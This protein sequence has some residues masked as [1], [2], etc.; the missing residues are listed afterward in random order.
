MQRT[1]K[2]PEADP[3]WRLK[4][5]CYS[6]G[7]ETDLFFPVGTTGPAVEQIANAK[8]VCQSCIAKLAC[9]EYALQNNI[10]D[11]IWGGTTEEERR[12]ILKKRRA[13]S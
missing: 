5:A 11:G 10:Q 2:A 7:G 3:S 1:N 9:L 4:A 8:A 12:A 13:A 6:A